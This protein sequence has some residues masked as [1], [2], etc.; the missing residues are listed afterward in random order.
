MEERK[1]IGLFVL[2]FSV[3]TSAGAQQ[4]DSLPFACGERL[5]FR[6]RSSKMGNVGRAVM[7]LSGP[8][9]IRGTGAMLASFNA[10]A[11][12]AFL[13]GSDATR[14]WF[15]PQDM[16]SLRYQKSERR[17]F[18]TN[19]DSVEIYAD[20]HHWDAQGGESGTVESDH[21]LDELA[22][23]YYLRTVKLLPDSLYS[24]DRHYDKRRAPATVRI[25]KYEALTTPAGE[26]STVE[27]EVTLSDSRDLKSRDV[28]KF[29]ISEDH[30]R[31]PV[32]IESVMPVLG[33]SNMT[34]ESVTAPGC[35]YAALK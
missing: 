21:P 2:M 24:F 7:A 27:Y 25:V 1:L 22:F 9:D 31:L 16:T 10:N 14:S 28:L 6:I 15:D 13:K 35:R 20:R 32:R 3:V 34:L 11:G 19:D 4:R 17:P 18:S 8:V 5:A 30:Q 29:W 33:T 23:I 26:F 12:V